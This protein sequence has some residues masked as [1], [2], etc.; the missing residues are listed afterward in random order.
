MAV[1]AE[2]DL[3]QK[4]CYSTLYVLG[5]GVLLHVR[6]KATLTQ[7]LTPHARTL[8]YVC[9]RVCVCICVCVCVRLC[10]C[11]CLDL[12]KLAHDLTNAPYLLRLVP[13]AQ[14]S[15]V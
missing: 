5:S 4:A 15:D 3:Q 11:V 7:T 1:L 12:G 10:V 13:C 14:L 9:A 6:K 2:R 8:V